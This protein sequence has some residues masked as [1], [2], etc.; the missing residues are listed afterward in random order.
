[1]RVDRTI[2]LLDRAAAAKALGVEPATDTHV[3]AYESD[4]TVTNT[5]TTAWRPQTGLVSIWIL[6]QLRPGPHTTVVI[7][8]VKGTEAERGP[9]VND[10]YFG[11]IPPDRLHVGDG[12]LF[13]RADGTMRGKIG[14]PKPRARD[15]AGSY[16]ADTHVL[17]IK[18]VTIPAEAPAGYVNSMWEH[19]ARPYGGDVVNSYN[20]GPLGPGQPPL[21]PF[22]EIES[23]SPALALAPNASANHVH[24]TIHVQG[25][26]AELDAIS[27]AVLGVSLQEIK[28]ALP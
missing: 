26:E 24:R 6:S 10:T 7:P 13:F 11:A 17:T 15:V 27:R 23:S 28:T 2:R 3:V 14:M 18:Q 21:G 19:Q 12:V 1:M 9:I 25:P 5:G 22:Y 20:D 16:D 8:F 4:N